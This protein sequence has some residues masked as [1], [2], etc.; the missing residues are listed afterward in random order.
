MRPL[1]IFALAAFALAFVGGALA[2]S[3]PSKPIKIVIPFPPGNTTDIMSRL[4]GPK[5]TE[6]L[7]Q[8]VLVE[9]RPGASGTLGLDFVAKAAPDGYTIAAGQGGNLAVLPHTSKT[10]PY[11]ALK[12]FTPI[13]VST[14]NYLGIVANPEVPFKTVGEMVAWAKANPGRLTVA[15]NGEGGFPHLAFE[16]LRIMGGFT[17]THI[18]Y[19]GSAQIATD[20]IGGQV[21]V[22]ID[23]ITGLAPHARSGRLRLLA[24]TNKTRVD[25]WPG[26]PAAAEDVPGYESGGWFGYVGPAGMPREIVAK[27]N[28][29]INRAIKLPEVSEKLVAGGLIVVAESPEYF[30]DLI[31]SDYAKYGKLVRDIGFQPQ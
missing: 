1:G 23:G 7:G 26:T 27:L 2:Q 15:T 6:R 20:L 5:I 19:K 18:P 21:Q 22:G 31:R 30:G 13:A 17:F 3:W 9:N 14:T 4:I 25:L 29:A 28:E 24:I 12:D 10:I 11:D 8:P 16:H